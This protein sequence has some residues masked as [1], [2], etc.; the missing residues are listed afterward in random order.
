MYSSPFKKQYILSTA[1]ATVIAIVVWF[2]VPKEYA[3][4]TKLSDEY[5][6]TDLAVGLTKISASMRSVGSQNEG[7][8]NIETYSKILSTEDFLKDIAETK[9]SEQGMTYGSWAIR[10]KRFWQSADTLERVREKLSFN[11][12]RN[13]QTIYIQFKDANPLVA[14]KMLDVVVKNLQAT[15][16]GIRRKS[17]ENQYHFL[18]KERTRAEKEYRD[19]QHAYAAFSDSHLFLQSEKEKMEF[20]KLEKEIS[21]KYKTYKSISD[22]CSRQYALMQKTYF[23]FAVV[24]PNTVPVESDSNPIIYLVAFV[25]LGLLFAKGWTLYEER[26]KSGEMRLSVG[27]IFAPWTITLGIWALIIVSA[28]LVGNLIYPIKNQFYYAIS[29]WLPIFCLVSWGTYTLLKPSAE[30]VD[31]RKFKIKYSTLVFNVFLAISILCTPLCVKKVMDIIM[32]FGTEDLMYN[33]RVL[34]IK[35][36]TGL[37]ILAYCFTINKALLILAFWR[38]PDI[39]KWQLALVIIL[40]AMNA[41]VDMDKGSIFFIA[42][43]AI[44]VLYQRGKIS[45]RG[46]TLFG[47]ALILVFF[48]F[49]LMR[50][51]TGDDGRGS[52]DDLTILEFIGIY[53]LTTPVAFSY[54]Q[55]NIGAPYGSYTLTTVYLILNRLGGNFPIIEQIQEFVWVPLPTNLY[56]IM[57]PFYLDFGYPGVAFF[58]VV[59]GVVCGWAYRSYRNGSSIGCV[60]YTYLLYY[61]V[62]QF[63]QEGL[64]MLPVFTMRMVFCLYLLTQNKFSL[65]FQRK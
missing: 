37:G 17:A 58:A 59:Y 1:I 40:F 9:V 13:Q 63:S 51:E 64:I 60:M 6:E 25:I 20:Q 14:S 12:S 46:I 39:K 45:I 36:E 4:Q 28:Q 5:K 48:V 41:F 24:K 53:V 32:M 15:I 62:L 43:T 61:L 44:F 19:A 38:Y 3:A 8:N 29:L 50:T 23:S 42:I 55:P 34:A 18:Q 33:M 54:M 21:T 2:F 56:T 22:N 57:Q 47:I 16:T 30:N 31:I 27:D 49:T 35:G 11:V 26:R 52:L 10:Q 65:S 7:I